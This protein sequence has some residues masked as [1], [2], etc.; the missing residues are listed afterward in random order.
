MNSEGSAGQGGLSTNSL[1]QARFAAGRTRPGGGPGHTA[2]EG[3]NKIR[4]N[5]AKEA[6]VGSGVST[7]PAHVEQAQALEE[8]AF[9]AL[10]RGHL[11]AGSGRRA[12]RE[13]RPPKSVI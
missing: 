10:L 4:I 6:V 11:R 13:K 3:R 5:I 7:A 1:C 12:R 2:K 9:L 8:E